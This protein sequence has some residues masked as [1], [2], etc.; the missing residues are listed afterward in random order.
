M[1]NAQT[2]GNGTTNGK[3]EKQPT[4]LVSHVERFGK[5]DKPAAQKD[6]DAKLKEYLKVNDELAEIQSKVSDLMAKRTSLTCDIVA[7]RGTSRIMTKTR[8]VGQITARGDSAWIAF[9]K[10]DGAVSDV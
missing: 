5:R 3:A 6:I 9:G 1:E 10:V 8:G 4:I 7:L 2:N